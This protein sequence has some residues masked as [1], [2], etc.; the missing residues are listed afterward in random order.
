MARSSRTEFRF[1]LIGQVKANSIELTP[2]SALSRGNMG[3]R[4][5]PEGCA[6]CDT[7]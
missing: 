5:G 1:P 2:R 7:S 4:K 6:P 3:V